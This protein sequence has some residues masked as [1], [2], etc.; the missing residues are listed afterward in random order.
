MHFSTSASA[1]KNTDVYDNAM[2]NPFCLSGLFRH[3]DVVES[4]I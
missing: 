1:D 2:G 3:F 4:P